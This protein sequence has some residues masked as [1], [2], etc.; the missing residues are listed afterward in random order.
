M[1]SVWAG[2]NA[3]SPFGFGESISTQ[4]RHTHK[5]VASP[6]SS[7]NDFDFLE[8]NWVIKN[9]KLKTRLTNSSDWIEFEAEQLTQKILLGNGNIDQF[10]TIQDNH[11]FEGMSL[12]L[13]NPKTKLW[14]IYWADSNMGSLEVPVVGSF[15]N[16]IGLFFAKD[17][18]QGNE[19]L[20]K[21][22]WEATDPEKPVWS[23]AF[24]ADWGKSWEWNWY[25]HFS[26]P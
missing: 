18:F 20:V 10:K 13:F 12:R 8:G 16:G 7:A 9:R 15:E 17:T 22:H 21:F 1:S 14:S 6:S 3:I 5:I 24:S 2:V 4:L 26:R 19:V 25:M 11:S 23:Q